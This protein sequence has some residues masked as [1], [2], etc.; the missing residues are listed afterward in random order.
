MI[1]LD[2]II[3]FEQIDNLTAVGIKDKVRNQC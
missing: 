1:D 2:F 3:T